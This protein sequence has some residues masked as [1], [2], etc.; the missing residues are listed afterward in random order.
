MGRRPQGWHKA[1]IKAAL[2]KAGLTVSGVADR[3]GLKASTPRAALIRPCYAGEQA[4][5]AELGVAPRTIWPERYDPDGTPK[6]PRA[7]LKHIAAPA[8][9]HRQKARAV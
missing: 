2:E 7:R 5:A 8:A 3:H 9:G 1:D 4:I 6:H